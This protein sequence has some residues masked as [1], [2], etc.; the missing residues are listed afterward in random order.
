[1][2]SAPKLEMGEVTLNEIFVQ[3]ILI[4]DSIP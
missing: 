3:L 2:F 4:T 1:M